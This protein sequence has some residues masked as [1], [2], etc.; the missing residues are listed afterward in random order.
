[1]KIGSG[2]ALLKGIAVIA[3]TV[4]L[5][6]P[7]A[8]LHGLVN[9]RTQLR[10]QAVQSVAQG[11]G[12]RQMVGGPLL[13]IPVSQPDDKDKNK[14]VTRDWYLL[15]DSTEMDIDLSVQKESR[16]LGIYEVPVY[17]AKVSAKT[18]F[19]VAREVARL[20]AGDSSLQVHV[21]RARLIVPVSDPRGLRD[22]KVAENNVTYGHL[23][24][25]RG[26]PT[27]TLAAPLADAATTPSKREVNLSLEIAG[28]ESLTFLPLAR[29]TRVR[30]GGNWA[31]PGFTSGF[32]PV[33]RSI[34]ADGF[35]AHW[36]VLDINRSYGGRWF[37]GD[38]S[39]ADLQ[40]S[41]FGVDLVQPVDLYQQVTR[42]VKYGALFIGLSLL[43][44]FLLEFLLGRP[45]HP[46]Q[47]GL[48]GL[49]LS[50]FYLLLLAL[51][52]HI[53]F[54]LAYLWAAAALCALLGVYIS[55]ALRSH[56]AG[57]TASGVFAG[58]YGLIY[59]LVTSEDYALL[60]GALALFALLATLMVITRKLDWYGAGTE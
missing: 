18:Q 8:M 2:S 30:M 26:F 5:L 32:L 34:D 6:V 47:Y 16:K 53:G 51:S 29:A 36:Q 60:A 15:P 7:L 14:T 24:P 20:T 43:T 21:E 42:A 35:K 58:V 17:V 12:G 41:A 33:E 57:M 46:I 49:A 39:L 23:E 52:E 25:A 50:V 56:L 38:V 9:E 27:A 48:M 55:G 13:A 37:E 28:T 11:W 10:E 54:G 22:V 19:D 45:M 59:L 1:M 4:V 40:Q 3:V 44:L 31:H